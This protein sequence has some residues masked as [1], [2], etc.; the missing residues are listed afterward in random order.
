MYQDIIQ[1][2]TRYFPYAFLVLVFL[3][4][5]GLGLLINNSGGSSQ[6]IIDK[7]AKISLPDNSGNQT[8]G[9]NNYKFL[10]NFMASINGKA[11]YPKNCSAGNRIKE[12]NKIWFA[13]KEEARSEEHT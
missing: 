2:S 4:G 3:I 7:N 11:Y 1:K 12:E 9:E 6:I 13:T 8:T 5:L 10:G